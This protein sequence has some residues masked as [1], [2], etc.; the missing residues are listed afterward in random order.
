[1]RPIPYSRHSIEQEDIAAVQEVLASDWLTTG[2]KVSEFEDAF[3]KFCGARE[4]VAVNSGTAALH[5]PMHSYGVGQGD[6]VIVPANTFA[7]SANAVLYAGGTPIFA[8]VQIDTGLIDLKDAESKITSRTKGIVAVDFAG[9]P[10]DYSELQHLTAKHGLFLH[11]DACHALGASYKGK[12]AGA[13]ACTSS[14]SFHPVKP[15]TTGE[16][17]MITTDDSELAAA[18]R[19]FRNHGITTDFRQREKAQT[20]EYDM[21][22]LGWNY[23]LSD[24]QCALGISQ[25]HRARRFFEARNRIANLYDEAFA[26]IGW[27][28]IPARRPDRTHA[29]HLY[30][31]RLAAGAPVTQREAFQRLRAKGIGAHVMYRPVYLHSYY[32]E[33]LG[34]SSTP[35]PNAETLYQTILVLPISA[36]MLESDASRVVEE[37]AALAL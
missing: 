25:L 11:A 3:A 36:V 22:C 37:V 4:A 27:L 14:F 12:A 13:L 28:Q 16:G 7:A 24:L 8:D 5:A 26:T 10:C 34:A 9:Q 32:Q 19:V 15:I 20:W 33:R 17:G 1:M 2:P 6:E 29:F 18:M 30:A 21:E 31:C 35:C 23:R